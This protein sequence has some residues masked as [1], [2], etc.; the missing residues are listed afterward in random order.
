VTGRRL[1]AREVAAQ[2]VARVIYD[3]AWARPVLEDA[4]SSSNLE[5]R[6]RAFAT[7]LA[8]GALRWLSPLEESLRRASDKPGKKV[9]AK[10]W[11]HLV[12]AA[13]QLQ[14]L[15]ERVP[16]RAAVH[17]CVDA[18]GRDRPGL[19]GF[20]NALLRHLA[21]PLD[22]QLAP[23]A[24]LDDVARAFGAP[25]VL[26]RGLREV[27]P[28]HWREELAATCAR[29]PLGLLV[30][31]DAPPPEGAA[32]HAFVPGAFTGDGLGDPRALAGWD[33]GALTVMDP[34]SAA[35]ALLAGDLEGRSALD[36]CAAPGGKSVVLA[37]RLGAR[38]SAVELDPRRAQRLGETFARCRVEADVHVGDALELDLAPAD[39]VM[40]DAPCTGFGTVRRRPEIKRQRKPADV[41]ARAQDQAALLARAADLVKPGGVLVY[42]VCSPLPVEGREQIA[43]LLD[44]RGD[45]KREP[46]GDVLPWLP[47]DAVDDDGQLQLSTALHHT[48]AFFAARLR[49]DP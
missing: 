37:R 40:L 19:K 32:P 26:A 22:A 4:L 41:E 3:D 6:D 43:R 13:Y 49:R 16:A 42:A 23:D 34:G 30:L 48:D 11:P 14:H 20:A 21:S 45:L 8:Y 28:D 12:V 7:E 46:A 2:V 33:E 18:V 27:F 10:V 24:E 17:A 5:P 25:R 39:L 35:V 47:A 15:D 38:V 9:D 1:S 29:P 44:A 36:L 31:D